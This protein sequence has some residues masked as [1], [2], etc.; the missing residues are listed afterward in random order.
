MFRCSSSYSTSTYPKLAETEILEDDLLE[1]MALED[2]NE[3]TR[4]DDSKGNRIIR[5]TRRIIPGLEWTISRSYT[6]IGSDPLYVLKRDLSKMPTVVRVTK[7]SDGWELTDE[8][9][10][11]ELCTYYKKDMGT[12]LD[13]RRNYFHASR[14]TGHNFDEID[15]V[16]VTE[17]RLFNY[18]VT[19]I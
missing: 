6:K 9:E 10:M 12:V 14:M 18:G 8:G 13:Y 5:L 11:K 2:A 17:E 3:K 4:L 7:T 16:T 19:K 15:E 1:M